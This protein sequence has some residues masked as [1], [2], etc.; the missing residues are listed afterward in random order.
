MAARCAHR[1]D[2]LIERLS[3]FQPLDGA[4]EARLVQV[5]DR[6]VAAHDTPK[7]IFYSS[8]E[9]LAGERVAP[10]G[11]HRLQQ[12]ILAAISRFRVR[13]TKL[14]ESHLSAALRIELDA[15][16]E[17]SDESGGERRYRLTSLKRH[18][19]SVRPQAVKA[20][21]ANHVEL[22]RLYERLDPSSPSWVGIKT[23][24][25]PMPRR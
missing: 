15:L 18:S 10:S 22:S 2:R 9:K 24:S 14:I 8:V 17:E 13:Q 5:I 6:Q 19:Q 21:L 20:R 23:T 4:H 1:L 3:G 25:G 16:L 12:L 11:Y 7:A